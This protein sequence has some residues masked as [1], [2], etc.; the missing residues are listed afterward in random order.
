MHSFLIAALRACVQ[1]VLV[2]AGHLF[3]ADIPSPADGMELIGALGAA[4]ACVGVGAAFAMLVVVMRSL[5]RK[6]TRLRTEIAGV[7]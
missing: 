7:I 4:V 1:V 5:L 6:A 2:A 3:V